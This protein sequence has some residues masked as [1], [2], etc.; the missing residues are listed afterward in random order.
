MSTSKSGESGHDQQQGDYHWS[1]R[2]N[3][4]TIAKL[5]EKFSQCSHPNKPG[6]RQISKELGLDPEQTINERKDLNVLRL[7][8]KKL[9]SENHMMKESLKKVL[10][11]DCAGKAMGPKEREL[12]MLKEQNV[13][14]TKECEKITSLL[15][16]KGIIPVLQTSLPSSSSHDAFQGRFLNQMGGI[17]APN[18]PVH[19]HDH[20]IYARDPITPN[21]SL[22]ASLQLNIPSSSKFFN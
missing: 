13:L 1:F 21:L 7:E 4:E 15:A 10:C 3:S 20:H 17:L 16:K 12:Q 6:R 8:N 19:G 18:Q 9:K 11:S 2:H 22:L 14:I 5:E